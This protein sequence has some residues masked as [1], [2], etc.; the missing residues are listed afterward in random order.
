MT[1]R[2]VRFVL[3]GVLLTSACNVHETV[4]PPLAGPSELA[5]SLV[6]SATPDHVTQDGASSS[7]IAITARDPNGKPLPNV[8][9]RFDISVNNQ[10]VEFGSLS[11]KTAFTN[12]SGRATVVYT[13]P[14]ASPF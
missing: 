5:L 4:A 7:T 3:A 9:L 6:M 10:L 13:P 1:R 2:G 12:G 8:E 14:V 11:T